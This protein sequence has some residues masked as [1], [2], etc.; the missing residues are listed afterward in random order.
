MCLGVRPEAHFEVLTGFQHAL[1]IPFDDGP[2]NDRSWSGNI[3][4]L[5]AHESLAKSASRW[6]PVHVW[7]VHDGGDCRMRNGGM[8]WKRV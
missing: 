2:V 8:Q 6:T 5:L 4:E 7:R 1:T 3:L